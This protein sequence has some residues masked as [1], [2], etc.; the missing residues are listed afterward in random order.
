MKASV[1]LV[2]ESPVAG[3][4]M[5]FDEALNRS[6][7]FTSFPFVLRGYKNGAFDLPLGAI[8]L[9]RESLRPISWSFIM[10]RSSQS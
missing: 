8:C 9:L 3:T 10:S 7:R 1:L 2:A 5:R 4:V 6:E